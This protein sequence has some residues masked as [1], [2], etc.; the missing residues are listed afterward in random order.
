MYISPMVLS[1]KVAWLT[2]NNIPRVM[3]T[4]FFG[5]G[6]EHISNYTIDVAVCGEICDEVKHRSVVLYSME[7]EVAVKYHPWQKS[8]ETLLM[9]YTSYI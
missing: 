3:S 8:K 5:L 2:N 9:K 7:K 6:H 4:W 1:R